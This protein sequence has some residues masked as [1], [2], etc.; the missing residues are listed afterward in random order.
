MSNSVPPKYA[1]WGSLRYP[2]RGAYR[3]KILR[4]AEHGAS[5]HHLQ[6]RTCEAA[7]AT[8]R[9]ADHGKALPSRA[10][11]ARQ[12]ERQRAAKKAGRK[13]LPADKRRAQAPERERARQTKK[14][15]LEK[16][17]ER[18]RAQREQ[19]TL[20]KYRA[21][22]GDEVAS[23]ADGERRHVAALW[24]ERYRNDPSFRERELARVAQRRAE[25][26]ISWRLPWYIRLAIGGDERHRI[27]AEKHLG[28]VTPR[29]RLC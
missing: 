14:L 22:Y 3:Q 25:R 27:I 5:P 4:S 19:D 13:Y 15:E 2:Q 17:R 23:I 24:R 29:K 1:A 9:Y 18:Q 8:A 11:K 7:K 28:Y 20:D 16:A 10:P 26:G 21:L 6:C 12:K